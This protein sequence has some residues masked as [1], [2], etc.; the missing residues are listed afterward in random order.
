M[1]FKSSF[2]MALQFAPVAISAE[3]RDLSSRCR[4]PVPPLA[5]PPSNPAKSVGWLVIRQVDHDVIV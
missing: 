1:T 2:L 3:T 4:A 5:A